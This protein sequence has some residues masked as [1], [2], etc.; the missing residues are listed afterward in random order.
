MPPLGSV[1]TAELAMADLKAHD[2]KVLSVS[3]VTRP[4]FDDSLETH[5]VSRLCLQD[6]DR[7]FCPSQS[8]ASTMAGGSQAISLHAWLMRVSPPGEAPLCSSQ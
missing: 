4:G 5:S 1:S 6:V 7:E 3:Q 2:P 8:D